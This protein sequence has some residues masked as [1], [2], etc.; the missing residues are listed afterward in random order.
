MRIHCSP[1]THNIHIPMGIP[2]GIPIHTAALPVAQPPYAT[3][4]MC[5]RF[6]KWLGTEGHLE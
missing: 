2:M 6:Y 1:Y 4:G 5:P 3:G